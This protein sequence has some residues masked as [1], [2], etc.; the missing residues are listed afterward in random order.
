MVD[1]RQAF[2]PNLR[3]GESAPPSAK[4]AAGDQGAACPRDMEAQTCYLTCPAAQLE[5]QSPMLAGVLLGG[6]KP[7]KPPSW[8]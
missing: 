3:S 1:S 7:C 8:Q 5:M 4:G 2:I 6:L